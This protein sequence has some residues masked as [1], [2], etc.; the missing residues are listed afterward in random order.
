MKQLDY[1]SIE[2]LA[3]IQCS[4]EEIAAFFNL[5]FDEWSE[6]KDKDVDLQSALDR[7]YEQ[8]KISLRRRQWKTAESGNTTMLIWLGKQYLNQ[9]DQKTVSNIDLSK[10]STDEL[11][12]LRDNIHGRSKN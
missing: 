8:G 3:I 10:L 6:L 11:L 7:G 2:K 4:E 9:S 1:E 12:A 5:T